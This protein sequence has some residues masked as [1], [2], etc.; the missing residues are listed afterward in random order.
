MKGTRM[1]IFVLAL[2]VCCAGGALLVFGL[3]L[4]ALNNGLAAMQARVRRIEIALWG[5][6]SLRRGD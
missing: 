5:A 3:W 6:I 1:Q 4:N 2:L